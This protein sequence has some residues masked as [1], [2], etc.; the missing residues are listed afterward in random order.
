MEKKRNLGFESSRRHWCHW[1]TR[2]EPVVVVAAV[3]VAVAVIESVVVVKLSR[4]S[5]VSGLMLTR[6]R[7]LLERRYINMPPF[8]N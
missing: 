5:L 6:T 3:S 4:P 1:Q 8:F 7:K 2:H